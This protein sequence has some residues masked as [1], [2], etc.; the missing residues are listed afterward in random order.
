[1]QPHLCTFTAVSAGKKSSFT[2][3]FLILTTLS[4]NVIKE[5][6]GEMGEIVLRGQLDIRDF[7]S[8]RESGKCLVLM[9]RICGT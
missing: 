1:M 6:M 8:L 7:I 4:N 2:I 9:W 5:K 3:V